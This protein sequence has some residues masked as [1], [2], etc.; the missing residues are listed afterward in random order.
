MTTTHVVNLLLRNLP[1]T[2]RLGHRLPGLIN[3]LLSVATLVDAGC[4]VYFHRTGCEVSADGKVILQGWRDPTNRLWR[5]RITDDDWTTNFCVSIPT[6]TPE[7]PTVPLS[8][9]PTNDPSTRVVP[10]SSGP[11]S[12][13]QHGMVD[14]FL[15]GCNGSLSQFP[16]TALA[17]SLYGCSNTHKLIHFN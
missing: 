1:V 14:P 4:D 3:N 9:A 7:P 5:V 16:S 6:N 11:L 8:T 15:R 12:T 17:N 13:I 10:A 2:A